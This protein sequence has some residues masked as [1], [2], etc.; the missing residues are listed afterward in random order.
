SIE[1]SP[2]VAMDYLRIVSQKQPSVRRTVSFLARNIA[3]L[4]G[5]HTF[6]RRGD[7]DRQRLTDHALARLLQQPNS[8]T[9]R[10]RFLN[11]LVHDFAIYDFAYW[12]KI[13]TALGPRLVHLPAPLITPKGDNW[14]TP[15]QFEFR[16]SR[17]ARLIPAD[18]VVY[19]RGY[20]GIADAGVS[21][22]NHSGRSC[23]RTRP[24]R[25]MRDQIMRNGAR[26]SGYISRPK[27]P[28]AEVVGR[29]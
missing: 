15:E 12:W 11:T 7:D 2:W 13:K 8:F 10:Y 16:D 21:P 28:D 24:L 20:G 25:R 23:A 26:H 9:T 14:L 29:R 3:Q 19:F 4:F 1:L 18:E 17:S 27:V 5:I 22:L 6:E